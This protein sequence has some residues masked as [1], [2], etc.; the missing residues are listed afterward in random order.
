MNTVCKN[1]HY[2]TR[3]FASALSLDLVQF[4]KKNKKSKKVIIAGQK[5]YVQFLSTLK[6]SKRHELNKE[7]YIP[8]DMFIYLKMHRDAESDTNKTSRCEK[9]PDVPT[10][11][12][13]LDQMEII[14]RSQQPIN[15]AI[16]I[17]CTRTSIQSILELIFQFAPSL[18]T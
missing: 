9:H 3:F 15:S 13:F 11:S 2:S 14:K 17:C 16:S 10:R 7:L 5:I 12:M 8:K 18:K 1:G 6:D 4:V